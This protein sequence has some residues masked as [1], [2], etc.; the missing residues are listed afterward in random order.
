MDVVS[1]VLDR[2]PYAAPNELHRLE[3]GAE[4]PPCA[5]VKPR[6]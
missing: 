1:I 2:D 6:P 3:R 5:S 4:K